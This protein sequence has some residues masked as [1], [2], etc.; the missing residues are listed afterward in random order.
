M[1][2]SPL[3]VVVGM[4][5]LGVYEQSSEGTGQTWPTKLIVESC[6]ADWCFQHDVE[7][8]GVMPRSANVD[9]PW[10]SSARDEQIRDPEATQ[11]GLGC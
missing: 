4:F 1:V 8:A 11:T 10:L 5:A 7:T 3:V 6:R 9:L 2:S